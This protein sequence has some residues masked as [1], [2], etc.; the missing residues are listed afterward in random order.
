MPAAIGAAL[1]AVLGLVNALSFA[2]GSTGDMALVLAFNALPSTAWCVFFAIL[3]KAPRRAASIALLF[4]ILPRAIYVALAPS[5]IPALLTVCWAL[6]LVVLLRGRGV[7][8]ALV[9][10]PLMILTA[11]SS[12][13]DLVTILSS[14]NELVTGA[15]AFF[16]RNNPG[17]T[18]WRQVATPA[19]L[20]FYWVTQIR[21]LLAVRHE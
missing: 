9:A 5:A 21:F 20:L 8:L 19:I 1:L 12:V 6:F 18:L 3:P 13:G 16:W 11:V 14:V 4:A 2:G 10:L 7:R 15:L 17:L